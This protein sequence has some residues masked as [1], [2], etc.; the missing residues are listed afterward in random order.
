[1]WVKSN[2]HCFAPNPGCFL[3]QLLYNLAV[4]QVHTVKSADSDYGIFKGRQLIGVPVYFHFEGA[5]LNEY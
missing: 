1:V 4:P 3:F 2:Q 5:K